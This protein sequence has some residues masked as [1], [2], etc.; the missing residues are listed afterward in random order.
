MAFMAEALRA[1]VFR[2]VS[3]PAINAAGT[4]LVGVIRYGCDAERAEMG[5]M[6]PH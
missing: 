5:P 3:S 4:A 2:I 1:M 6:P